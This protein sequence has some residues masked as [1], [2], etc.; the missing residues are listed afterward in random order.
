[1]SISAWKSLSRWVSTRDAKFSPVIPGRAQNSGP[2]GLFAEPGLRALGSCRARRRRSQ[3]IMHWLPGLV[4]CLTDAGRARCWAEQI[5]C[6]AG[7]GSGLAFGYIFASLVST[8]IPNLN[9]TRPA[10]LNYRPGN[11]SNS[12]MGFTGA[13]AR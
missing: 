4:R 5:S 1:M 11:S 13:R 10:F 12:K 2:A 3:C 7:L 6:G 9:Q 8:H